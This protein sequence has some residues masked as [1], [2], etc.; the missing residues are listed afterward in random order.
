MLLCSTPLCI[1]PPLWSG[2]LVSALQSPQ[3]FPQCVGASFSREWIRA[4][5]HQV[6]KLFGRSTMPRASFLP[7]CVYFCKFSYQPNLTPMTRATNLGYPFP[8]SSALEIWLV[9][10]ILFYSH[11]FVLSFHLICFPFKSSS[12]SDLRRSTLESW[13]KEHHG[14]N[15]PFFLQL[16]FKT[17]WFIFLR[18]WICLGLKELWNVP[19]SL[20]IFLL[21]SSAL[22]G[23]AIIATNI[24]L[25]GYIQFIWGLFCMARWVHGQRKQSGTPD[26]ASWGHPQQ[27]LQPARP[28][29]TL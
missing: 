21:K 19:K 12:R 17:P 2:A 5:S 8:A 24:C 10:G 29:L 28:K 4:N 25:F 7:I 1:L 13:P 23:F 20:S 11:N 14:G 26:T 16:W 3:A 9:T 27:H 22:M 18:C 6:K 15:F